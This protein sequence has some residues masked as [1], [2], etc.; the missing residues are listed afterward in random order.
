MK[1]EIA[2]IWTDALRS[3]KYKQGMGRLRTA[4]NTFCCLGVLCDLAVDAGVLPAPK[5][6]AARLYAY[7]DLTYQD[8]CKVSTL[9][10][11]VRKWAGMNTLSGY[12]SI[13]EAGDS[14]TQLNDRGV[15]FTKI[16]DIIDL[17]VDQL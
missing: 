15:T 6:E 9:P 10:E 13:D 11:D 1:P 7:E 4:N 14:L 5:L 2:T 12:F 17:H 8:N 16:A 3:G